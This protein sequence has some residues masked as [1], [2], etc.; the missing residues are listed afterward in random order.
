M[1]APRCPPDFWCFDRSPRNLCCVSSA[2][3]SR[4]KQVVTTS[5]SEP[6][7]DPYAKGMVHDAADTADIGRGLHD[8]YHE[9]FRAYVGENVLEVG[10]GSGSMASILLDRHN[11]R[12]YV[13]LEPSSHYF[14]TLTMRFANERRIELRQAE[15]AEV[16]AE[17]RDAFDTVY[18]GHV[19]EHIEDDRRF[20]QDCL[21]MT[22]DGGYVVLQVPA[23]PFLYSRLDEKIGHFRR[24]DKAMLRELT[25]DLDVRWVL[26][27]YNNLPAVV[28]SLF[29]LRFGGLDFQSGPG[30]KKLF[31]VL[32]G[33]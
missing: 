12:R 10:G 20:L 28:A 27:Q 22:K 11:P 16:I 29:V 31:F 23:L 24:Y 25:R 5:T 7:T 32:Y 15:T 17:Y 8:F 30:R 14:R 9:I 3:T 6:L 4:P 2:P 33:A 21:A 13:V 18:A 26:L 1:P 19:M